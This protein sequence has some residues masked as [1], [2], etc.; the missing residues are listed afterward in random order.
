MSLRAAIVDLDGTIYRGGT[1]IPGAPAAV[2]AL[3]D[4]GLSVLFF[5]N[6]PTKTPAEYVERLSGFG[7]EVEEDQVLTSGVV[8]AAYLAANHRSEEIYLI[9]EE[10]LRRQLESVTLTTDPEAAE[11]V[12]ASI[13]RELTFETL[14]RGVQALETGAHPFIGTDPDGM[15]PTAGGTSIPGTG[16]ILG[17]LSGAID[18]DPDLVLGKPS[19]Q[20]VT[21]ALD[22]LG[23]PAAECLVVG[24]RV[25]TDIAMGGRNGMQT[26]LVLS[27]AH[28][29]W[30]IDRLPDTPDSVFE[31]IAGVEKVLD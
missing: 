15:I 24:D 30:H 31:S 19:E 8:T 18:R 25:D 11:V 16:A 17:A 7:I 2:Q 26:A 14:T 22:R 20:A 23:V 6:N 21:M 29:E 10:G 1:L 13:D 4:A 28:N 5:S 27:G 9:G 3:R 12:V